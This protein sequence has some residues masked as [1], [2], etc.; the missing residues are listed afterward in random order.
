AGYPASLEDRPLL[1]SAKW[2]V[3]LVVNPS[4]ANPLPD[5]TFLNTMLSSNPGYTGWPPWIDSRAFGDERTHPVV[6]DN[7]WESLIVS[8]GC[9]CHLAFWRAEPVGHFY[10]LRNLQDDTVVDRVQPR[11]FLDPTLVCWR[12]TEVLA[13]GL[14]MVRALG[15]EPDDTRLAYSFKWEGLKGRELKTW[16]DAPI[17]R[18]SGKAHDDEV[19]TCIELPLATSP[20]A[21]AAAVQEVVGPLFAIFH[22]FRATPSSV[23]EIVRRVLERRPFA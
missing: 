18:G 2:S 12:I 17:I 6:R 9:P 16:S 19:T 8:L 10:L 20:S 5:R 3:A 13:V 14:A 21:L 22:G 7:G 15:W 23:D 4:H 1:D 11:T